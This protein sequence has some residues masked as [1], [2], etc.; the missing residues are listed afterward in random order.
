[1]ISRLSGLAHEREI[2]V[3]QE[4]IDLWSGGALIQVAMPNLSRAEREF[5]MTGATQEEWDTRV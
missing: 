4:Q 1:M 5:L 3:T 2:D